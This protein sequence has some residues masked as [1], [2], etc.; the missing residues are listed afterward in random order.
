M[1]NRN[2]ITLTLMISSI[3]LLVVLQFLWIRNSYE[4]AFYDFRRETNVLFRSTVLAMRDSLF[5][6]NIE[7]VPGDSSKFIFESGTALPLDS[8]RLKLD[9][10]F[11]YL[12]TRD[13]SAKVQVFVSSTSSID[14]VTKD[15]LS[16]LASRIQSLR[17]NGRPGAQRSFIIR[18]SPDTLSRDSIALHYQKVLAHADISLPFKIKYLNTPEHYH[19]DPFSMPPAPGDLPLQDVKKGDVNVFNDTITS[20]PVRL[21]PITHYSVSLTNV[22]STLL[23]QIT[24]E[25]LFSF[26]LTVITIAAF[27]LLYRNIRSQQ[28]LMEL[29]NDFISNVTHELKTPVA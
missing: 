22:R 18:L 17:I 24:P 4:K 10:N 21:N 26:F 12:G 11:T 5:A 23:R 28:R 20:D 29:K 2:T 7:S 15:D 27:L 8:A 6:K 1:K 25:I 14:T 19:R 9:S 3:L 16:P 13:K